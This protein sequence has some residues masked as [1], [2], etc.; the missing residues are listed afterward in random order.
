MASILVTITQAVILVIQFLQHMKDFLTFGPKACLLDKWFRE[1]N[2]P[3]FLVS[4][5][6]IIFISFLFVLPLARLIVVQFANLIAG[7]TTNER[8]SRQVMRNEDDDDCSQS[9]QDNSKSKSSLD[10]RFVHHA[11]DDSD[12]SLLSKDDSATKKMKL[13]KNYMPHI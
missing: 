4:A 5:G 2:G 6:L 12:A 7:K 13:N 8:F 1:W 9:F 10:L 3:V 11:K